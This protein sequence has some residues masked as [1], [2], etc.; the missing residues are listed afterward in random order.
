MLIN[1]SNSKDKSNL[2]SICQKLESK[3]EIY[4]NIKKNIIE[5]Y[6]DESIKNQK[7]KRKRKWESEPCLKNNKKKRFEKNN[8]EKINIIKN[9]II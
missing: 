6:F 8:S 4:S 7:K 1:S 2:A 5:L 3:D 9:I